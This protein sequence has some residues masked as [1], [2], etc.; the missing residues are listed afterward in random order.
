MPARGDVPSVLDPE[1]GRTA[2]HLQ[3]LAVFGR[4]QEVVEYEPMPGDA[5]C[6]G[7]LVQALS[8]GQ[9]AAVAILVGDPAPYLSRCH[10]GIVRT[11]TSG[12]RS[13]YSCQGTA[14]SSVG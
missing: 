4:L 7:G 6:G 10:A 1:G 12:C 8:A 2:I 9:I 11:M 5:G 13:P 14:R 3:D